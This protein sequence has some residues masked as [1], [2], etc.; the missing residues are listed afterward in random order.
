MRRRPISAQIMLALL[1]VILVNLTGCKTTSNGEDTGKLV[2]AAR[3]PFQPHV[4]QVSVQA[5]EGRYPNLFTGGS[6]ATWGSMAMSESTM[7]AQDASDMEAT[8]AKMMESSGDAITKDGKTDKKGE[9]APEA[10]MAM[11]GSG[12][13][14]QPLVIECYLESEFP[15][16]SIA[17]DAVGLRGIQFHLELPDGGEVLPVQKTL[18]SNLVEVPVG[19]L[20]RYGRKVTLYFPSRVIMVNNPAVTPGPSGIRLVLSGHESLFYFEWPARPDTTASEKPV[21]WDAHALKAS[22]SAYRGVS[23]GVKRISHEFD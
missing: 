19:A 23:T 7:G 8:E 5:G 16:M 14:G 9:M 11:A 13:P 2:P 10:K 3:I 22:Q 6:S 18:D 17:Y 4:R 12:G 15:D 20:R 1:V 21:R